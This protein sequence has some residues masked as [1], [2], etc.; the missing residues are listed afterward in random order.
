MAQKGGARAPFNNW[1][2]DAGFEATAEHRT[3]VEL[4]VM[5]TLPNQLAGT[6]YRIGPGTYKVKDSDFQLSH[7][8]DGF[9]FVHRFELVPQ[10]TTGSCKVFYNARGQVDALTEEARKSGTLKGMTFGQKRDPCESIFRKVKSFFHPPFNSKDPGLVN[11]G[12]T[13]SSLQVPGASLAAARSLTSLTDANVLK[14]INPE[15]LEPMGVT[16]QVDLHPDLKGPLSCAHAEVDPTTGDFYNFNLN[17][18]RYA[19]Y[20]IFRTSATTGQT[21]ILATITGPEVKAAYLHSFFLSADYVILCVWPANYAAGGLKI[22]WERNIADAISF[23]RMAP[24]RWYV[25]DKVHGQGVVGTYLSPAFFCFH[26]INAWQET[27]RA[28]NDNGDDDDDD[29]ADG[30]LTI[31]DIFCDIIQY[32]TD[33]MIQRAYYD[34]MVSTGPNVTRYYG[35]ELSRPRLVRYRLPA[36][37]RAAKEDDAKERS[38]EP[39]AILPLPN[40]EA[41]LTIDNDHCVGDLPTFNPRFRTRKTR[42]VYNLINQGKVYTHPSIHPESPSALSFCSSQPKSTQ[43]EGIGGGRG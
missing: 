25:V 13:A 40:A 32:P 29:D 37:T 35:S 7:W 21:E 5:G 43:L 26:T 20:R 1:P 30:S 38:S 2:N 8:F 19:T 31:T 12:V 22:L 36:V 34:T 15:T 23:D 14:H 6:L 11:A 18:R 28:G 27:N 16:R 3:P 10:S 17:M 33:E 41:I 42:Y 4:P 24:A 9:S 39:D